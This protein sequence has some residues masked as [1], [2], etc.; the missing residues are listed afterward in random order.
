MASDTQPCSHTNNDGE[1]CF[2]LISL[3]MSSDESL[4]VMG[5][6]LRPPHR[7]AGMK[8]G[9]R[10]RMSKA[11]FYIKRCRVSTDGEKMASN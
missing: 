3:T 6:E 7:M 9:L 10:R 1:N 11:I 5:A 4:R 8:V 2:H